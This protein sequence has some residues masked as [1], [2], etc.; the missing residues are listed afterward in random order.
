VYVVF[1]GDVHINAVHMMTARRM[2]IRH[3][4]QFW[5]VGA[6]TQDDFV[7]GGAP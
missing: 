4:Q 2:V 6:A 5:Q 3:L 7:L 1:C